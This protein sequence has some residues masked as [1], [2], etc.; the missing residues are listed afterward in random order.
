[1]AKRTGLASAVKKPVTPDEWVKTQ[2]AGEVPL[3]SQTKDE[4]T[5]PARL[6]VEIPDDMHT[7]IKVKCAQERIKIKDVTERLFQRW[8]DGEVQL[9]P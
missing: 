2:P 8:L 7:R 1:M 3:T 9:K 4:S 5:K 6:V